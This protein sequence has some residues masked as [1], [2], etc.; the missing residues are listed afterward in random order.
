MVWSVSFSLAPFVLGFSGIDAAFYW[1]NGIT[2]LLVV[3]LHK[4]EE[5]MQPA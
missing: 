5:S 2:V 4:S 1:L 3:G